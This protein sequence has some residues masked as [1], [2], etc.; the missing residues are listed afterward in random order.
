MA[1]E[2]QE[3]P[4]EETQEQPAQEDPKKRRNQWIAIIAGVLLIILLL[5][6]I[7]YASG[8]FAPAQEPGVTV[9]PGANI[10]IQEPQEG[11][12]VD[13]TQPVLVRGE[14]G[15]LFEGNVVVQAFDS[16]GNIVTQQPTIIDAPDAGTGGQGSWEV[17]LEIEVEPGTSGRIYAFSPSAEDGNPM[18]EDIVSVT[19]GEDEEALEA[20][21]RISEPENGGTVDISG[22]FTV[23]GTGADLP[24]GNV[25][26]QALDGGGNVLAEQATVL[27]SS[28][29]GGEGAWKVELSVAVEP[30][31]T[32]TI[33][34]FSADPSSGDLLADVSVGVTY[35][36]PEEEEEVKLEDHLWLLET[37]AG[38]PPIPGTLL[39][40]EFED[41]KIAGLAGCNEYTGGYETSG[42]SI[43]IGELATTRKFC[44]EPEGTMDQESSY[45]G[46]LEAVRAYR[47]DDQRLKMADESGAEILVYRAAVVGTVT[48]GQ[49]SE[50]PQGT[51]AKIKLEDV[52]IANAAAITISEVNIDDPGQFP[53][54]FALIYDPELIEETNDYAVGVRIEDTAG[55]LLYINTTVV[56]VITYDHP[57]RVEVIVERVG[58]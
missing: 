37:I 2:F 33:R 41:G 8:A 52:S 9:V 16:E 19:Y 1:E 24:E 6:A 11:Q 45:L 13:I 31:S 17:R 49:G 55:S 50:I 5:V 44:E 32:G 22:P 48:D 40:A 56:S 51:V 3:Q 42:S 23:S 7:G 25:N 46:S 29:P 10:S 58:N 30:G 28:E 15:G 18:A 12:T 4:I 38:Q 54:P 14:G 43:Q 53:I 35:G 36:E 27:D 26:V 21:L 34:A 57:S 47:I 20:W 39:F